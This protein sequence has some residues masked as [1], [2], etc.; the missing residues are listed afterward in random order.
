MEQILEQYL[1]NSHH[2]VGDEIV[3][4]LTKINND[5]ATWTLDVSDCNRLKAQ[6]IADQNNAE[7]LYSTKQAAKINALTNEILNYL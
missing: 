4:L 2:L 1:N 3:T 6:L 7:L 5:I